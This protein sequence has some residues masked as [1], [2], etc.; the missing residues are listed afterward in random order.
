[1]M[2]CKIFIF[3]TRHIQV[4]TESQMLCSSTRDLRNSARSEMLDYFSSANIAKRNDTKLNRQCRLLF[5]QAL[6]W[7]E[8]RM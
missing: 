5:Y 8:P 7:L 1:M 4:I 6:E 3:T 2:S